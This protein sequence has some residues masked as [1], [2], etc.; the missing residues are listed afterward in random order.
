MGA[1][2]A[3]RPPVSLLSRALLIWL[4][5]L[6]LATTNGVVREFLLI[7]TIESSIAQTLSGLLLSVLILGV[8]WI[9]LPWLGIRTSSRALLVGAFWLVLT[10]VFEFAVGIWQGKSWRVLLQAY[11]FHG[12]TIWPVVLLVTG[13]SPWLALRLRQRGG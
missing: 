9:S 10:L 5:I 4:V 1:L 12:G 7:Q 3:S 6:V 2:K 13:L 8:A 11:T